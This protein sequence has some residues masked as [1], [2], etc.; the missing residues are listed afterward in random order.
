MTITV[1]LVLLALLAD[2]GQEMYGFQICR[3]TGLPGGTVYPILARLTGLGWTCSRWEERI[4]PAREGRPRRRY[5]LLTGRGIP[6][7]RAALARA[8]VRVVSVPA[9]GIGP[10]P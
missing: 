8:P 7:A 6:E 4:D 1:Q 2:P 3:A 9:A 10:G 5:Y